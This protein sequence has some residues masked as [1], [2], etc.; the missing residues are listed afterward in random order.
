VLGLR[1]MLLATVVLG[2]GVCILVDNG[3]AMHNILD[4]NSNWLA[5]LMERHINIKILVDSGNEIANQGACFNV[6]LH[7]DAEMF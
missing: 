1:A 5:G 6:P 4:V 7:I 3:G 2:Q